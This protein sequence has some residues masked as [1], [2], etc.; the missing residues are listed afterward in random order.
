MLGNWKVRKLW[1]FPVWFSILSGRNCDWVL[2]ERTRFGPAP[3]PSHSP[4]SFSSWPNKL[5]CTRW[6][7]IWSS[8]FTFL[9]YIAGKQASRVLC[10]LFSKAR[11]IPIDQKADGDHGKVD[12]FVIWSDDLWHLDHLHQ[13][14]FQRTKKE[15]RNFENVL[16]MANA[17]KCY[18]I[19][20]KPS[21]NLQSI[22]KGIWNW[23]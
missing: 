6:W 10:G 13:T 11:G 9:N 19:T 8:W 3:P 17:K 4:E 15:K 21:E 18:K 23:V 16:E 7:T 5:H 2:K 20:Q 22:G 12:S 14:E 1:T